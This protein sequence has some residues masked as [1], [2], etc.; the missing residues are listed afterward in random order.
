MLP[1]FQSSG[2]AGSQHTT[3][4]S[5]GSSSPRGTVL[6]VAAT[7]MTAAWVAALCRAAAGSVT[8]VR[9]KL[10]FDTVGKSLPR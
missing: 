6:L 9:G 1:H 10:A 4:Q 5:W 3:E 2:T 8:T 7:S